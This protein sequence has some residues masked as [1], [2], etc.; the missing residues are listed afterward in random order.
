MWL[1]IEP[2]KQQRL[3]SVFG[4]LESGVLLM[5]MMGMAY[6]LLAIAYTIGAAGCLILCVTHAGG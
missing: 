6:G 4:Q 1:E 3:R 5:T 2:G